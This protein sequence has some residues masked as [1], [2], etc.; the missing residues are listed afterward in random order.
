MIEVHNALILHFWCF[1]EADRSSLEVNVLIRIVGDEDSYAD[2]VMRQT[3]ENRPIPRPRP[4]VRFIR[5][6]S[7]CH[8]VFVRTPS[9]CPVVEISPVLVGSVVGEGRKEFV[10][11]VPVGMWISST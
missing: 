6:F 1:H 9:S 4:C 11:E 7:G 2:C 10:K 3:F 5:R 8:L